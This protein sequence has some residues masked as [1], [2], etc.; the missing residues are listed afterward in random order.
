MSY[1]Q[2]G[3]S[4]TFSSIKRHKGLFGLITLLQI[5]FVVSSLWLGAQYLIKILENT[6]GII[7]PL[8]NANYDSQMIEKGEPFTPD[9]AL[10]YHSYQSMLK[11][12]TVFASWLALLF[13]VFNGSIWLLSHWMMQ[14]ERSWKTRAKEGAHFFL[15]A[16]ASTL[17]LLGPFIAISYYVLLHFIRI[18]DTFSRI[19][20]ILKSL[21]I[22]LFV[23]YYF[24]LVALAIA[25][26]CSWKGFFSAWIRLSIIN[27]RKTVT[28]FFSMMI[29]LLMVL[30]ALYA[31]VE[32]E[33]SALLLLL[34][35]SLSML[36]LVVTRLF[37]IA[38][39]QEIRQE[40]EK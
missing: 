21:L 26:H 40:T 4:K 32:Y 1:L 27:F 28:L 23:L 9:Y 7:G 2:R 25:P 18:S 16:W 24:L 5:I 14:D 29:V 13:L 17:L 34:L 38:G 12:I 35:G 37:W 15:K 10:I 39:I 22:A 30:A 8:E 3:L 20:V 36:V 31:A 19:A 6:Q 11:N 33:K